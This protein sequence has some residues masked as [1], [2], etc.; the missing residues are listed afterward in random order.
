[1]EVKV[2]RLRQTL[3]LVGPAVGKTVE[4]ENVL[5]GGGQVCATDHKVTI[6]VPF[7]ES[8]G[9]EF[10]LPYK[11]ALKILENTPGYEV[12]ILQVEGKKA[13]FTTNRAVHTIQA[14]DPQDFPPPLEEPEHSVE[15]DGDEFLRGLEVVAPYAATDTTRPIL[16][17]V[18]MVLGDPV[19]MVAADGFRLA[20]EQLRL[21]VTPP[22]E[23]EQINVPVALVKPL[24]AVWRNGPKTPMF[25]DLPDVAPDK[26]SVKVAQ[27]AV[28]T[29]PM[30]L[31]F[32]ENSMACR[33]G[34]LT[35]SAPLT[36]GDFP[37]YVRLVPEGGDHK[38]VVD[39]EE[40]ARGLQRLGVTQKRKDASVIRLSWNSETLDLS[41]R[42][43][44]GDEEATVSLPCAIQGEPFRIAFDYKYLKAYFEV[45]DGPVLL[46]CTTHELPGLFTHRGSLQVVLMPM[47]V[48][49]DAS[50]ASEQPADEVE[51][52]EEE[53]PE[54]EADGEYDGVEEEG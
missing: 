1:M 32:G 39:A 30:E 41:T 47:F 14:G 25:T 52:V 34:G 28:A 17:T 5:I 21:S 45:R 31:A 35:V 8:E 29:R 23:V 3:K 40:M 20:L 37:N 11:A 53:D 48:Q 16:T 2:E 49:W 38:V 12:V 9:E 54:E 50:D 44:E 19:K 26:P 7:L 43:K 13:S 33:F 18:H 15:V 24:K 42:S 51:S 4:T 36:K 6:S 10:L 46:E 22:E 27:M